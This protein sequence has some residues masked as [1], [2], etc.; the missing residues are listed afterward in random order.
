MGAAGGNGTRPGLGAALFVLSIP[1]FAIR[2]FAPQ[3][4]TLF[5]AT[6]SLTSIL[7][8]GYSWHD[9]HL[10]V[11][12]NPGIGYSVA[13]RVG[14][15]LLDDHVTSTD[16][17]LFLQRALLV[18]I[19]AVRLLALPALAKR[20]VKLSLLLQGVAFVFMLLPPQSARRLVRRTHA[21]CILEL[22]RIYMAVV[23]AWTGEAERDSD[24]STGL[25]FQGGIF[26]PATRQVARARLLALRG[27][28]Y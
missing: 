2:L 16:V 3:T 17:R 9:G 1:L 4:A 24:N 12:G 6:I 7:I 5:A 23:S 26:S 20:E 25:V 10:P 28:P 13:W 11:V 27:K 8:V 14:R 18:L 15:S 19:G 21:T 22:G